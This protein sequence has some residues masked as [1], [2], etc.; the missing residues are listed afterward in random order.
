MPSTNVKAREKLAI[1]GTIDPQTVVNTEV[2]T[3]VVDVSGFHQVYGIALLGNMAAETVDFKAYR[4]ASDGN[5]AVALTSATQLAA[6]ATNNDN[7]QIAINVRSD[8]LI[9]SGARYIKFGLV[10]GGA[11]G[12]AAAVVALGVDARFNPASSSNLSSVAET[13]G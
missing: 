1:L 5:S 13:A 4:C 9:A 7:K 3:D 2:F 11:T 6:H 12:G 10:T 8:D